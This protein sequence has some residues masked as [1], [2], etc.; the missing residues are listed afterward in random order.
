MGTVLIV[1]ANIINLPVYFFGNL[2]IF[3]DAFIIII[4]KFSG[5]NFRKF[6]N[7]CGK[8]LLPYIYIENNIPGFI[9]IPIILYVKFITTIFHTLNSLFIFIIYN[10]KN[11]GKKIL[12]ILKFTHRNRFIIFT[13]NMG[14]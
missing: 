13:L 7:S 3:R 12:G 5:E 11:F 10:G 2:K 4:I 9:Y 1:Y 8:H 14:L 6:E